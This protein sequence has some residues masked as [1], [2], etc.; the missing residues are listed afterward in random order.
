M[1]FS[2]LLHFVTHTQAT[3]TSHALHALT[4]SKGPYCLV[5]GIHFTSKVAPTMV[6]RRH[7]K[8]VSKVQTTQK[9][10]R[11]QNNTITSQKRVAPIS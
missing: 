8:G 9:E 4:S 11:E 6:R 10:N 7:N 3:L 2:Q 1:F 5:L